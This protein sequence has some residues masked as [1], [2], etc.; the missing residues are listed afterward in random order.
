MCKICKKH[1]IV[2][3]ALLYMVYFFLNIF[4]YFFYWHELDCKFL[5][6]YL[7]SRLNK[8]PKKKTNYIQSVCFP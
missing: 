7:K 4:I 1:L 3:L 2:Y 6:G 5:K 8:L